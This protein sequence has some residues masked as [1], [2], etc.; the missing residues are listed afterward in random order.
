M[1]LSLH[2]EQIPAQHKAS[3]GTAI[4]LGSCSPTCQRASWELNALASHAVCAQLPSLEDEEKKSKEV[5]YLI[6]ASGIKFQ[7][8][9]QEAVG[10]ELE[11]QSQQFQRTFWNIPEPLPPQKSQQMAGSSERQEGQCWAACRVPPEHRK[12]KEQQKDTAV[13]IPRRQ[14]DCVHPA[15]TAGGKCNGVEPGEGEEQCFSCVFLWTSYSDWLWLPA[16]VRPT[17]VPHRAEN[18]HSVD[19]PTASNLLYGYLQ[20]KGLGSQTKVTDCSPISQFTPPHRSSAKRR[21][22]SPGPAS[23]P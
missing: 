13:P 10:G 22:K 17:F 7:A 18:R 4:N 9:Q 5:F 15:A 19:T 2:N 16:S 8:W 3:S 21:R 11:F 20:P 1:K 23:L 6:G 14:R 12:G